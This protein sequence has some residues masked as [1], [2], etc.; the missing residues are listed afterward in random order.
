M[1]G[2]KKTRLLRIEAR[3]RPAAAIVVDR[4]PWDWYAESCSCGLPAG[5]CRA[6]PRGRPSQRPPR[7]RLA[8]LG[9]RGRAR[10]GQDACRGLLDP[11][12]RPGRRHE[13]RLPDRPDHGRHP[14]RHGRGPLGAAG[15]R[16]TVVPASIRAATS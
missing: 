13:A 10:G 9:L 4:S 1:Y 16:A 12:P 5:E 11:A 6:H 3:R 7:G 2:T 14:R 15:G 8:G